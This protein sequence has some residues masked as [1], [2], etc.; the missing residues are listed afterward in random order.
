MAPGSPSKMHELHGAVT[1]W[2]HHDH[3]FR[4]A[5]RDQIVEDHVGMPDGRPAAGVVTVAVQQVDHRIGSLR[6]RV[7][8]IWRVNVIAAVMSL[9]RRL[10]ETTLNL[11]SP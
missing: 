6:R 2:H 3:G 8:P 9:H 7:I 5:L 1:E 4:L 11:A 10:T